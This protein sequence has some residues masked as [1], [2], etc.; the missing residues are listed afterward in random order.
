MTKM[1]SSYK[2]KD[3]FRGPYEFVRTWENGTFALRTV[4]VTH[5][6]NIRNIKLYNDADV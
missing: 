1:M 6:I 2:L 5:R 3:P 4:E